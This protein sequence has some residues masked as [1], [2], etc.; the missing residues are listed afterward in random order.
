MSSLSD[1]WSSLDWY[2]VAYFVALENRQSH[3]R[4]RKTFM[5]KDKDL[6]F[7]RTNQMLCSSFTE[8][9]DR[10]KFEDNFKRLTLGGTSCEGVFH[11][12]WNVSDRIMIES[13]YI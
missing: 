6:R 7:I 4:K 2:L 8:L 1:P 5:T 13:Y 10:K 12:S 3:Y 9:L 11:S